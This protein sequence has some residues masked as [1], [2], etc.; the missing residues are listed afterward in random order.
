MFLYFLV[1]LKNI[2]F[3]RT[4]EILLFS[5]ARCENLVF[6]LFSQLGH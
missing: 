4:K 5:G 2:V 3:V 6:S 1:Q